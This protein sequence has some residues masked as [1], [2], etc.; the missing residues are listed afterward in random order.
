MLSVTATN[1]FDKKRVEKN[2][3]RLQ[4]YVADLQA[5]FLVIDWPPMDLEEHLKLIRG[6]D[7]EGTNDEDVSFSQRDR[8]IN[9][10]ISRGENGDKNIEIK[11][12]HKVLLPALVKILPMYLMMSRGADDTKR[13]DLSDYENMKLETLIGLAEDFLETGKEDE[14]EGECCHEGVKDVQRKSGDWTVVCDD[15]GRVFE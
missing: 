6:E 13:F 14:E 1:H 15:C 2:F 11:L 4:F 7:V 5:P 8:V 10:V 9:I 12:P 3:S